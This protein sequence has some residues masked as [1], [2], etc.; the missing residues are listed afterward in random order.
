MLMFLSKRFLKFIIAGGLAA[1]LHWMSRIALSEVVSYLT[2]II[3][4]FFIGLFSG[5]ILNRVLVFPE[6]ELP[7]K[8]QLIRFLAINLGTMPFIWATAYY[9]EML[10]RPIVIDTA[11]RQ[12]IAHAAGVSLPILTS[13][14]LYSIWAFRIR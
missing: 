7:F 2:A 9:G 1:S 3:L 8:L 5:Y 13:F 11:V 6:S 14:F 12:A 4:S 10:L